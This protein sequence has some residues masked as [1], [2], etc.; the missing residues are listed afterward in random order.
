MSDVVCDEMIP[1]LDASR[2]AELSKIRGKHKKKPLE[3]EEA[4]R[5]QEIK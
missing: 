4:R 2:A 5:W 1:E 3:E